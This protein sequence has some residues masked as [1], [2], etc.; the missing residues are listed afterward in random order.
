MTR[1]LVFTGYVAHR[2]GQIGI[3]EVGMNSKPAQSAGQEFDRQVSYLSNSAIATVSAGPAAHAK[4][5]PQNRTLPCWW[6]IRSP[7]RTACAALLG[8][9]YGLVAK[10]FSIRIAVFRMVSWLTIDPGR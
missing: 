8:V 9:A 10:Y 2:P 7:P 6:P 1:R 4:S 5:P 3:H